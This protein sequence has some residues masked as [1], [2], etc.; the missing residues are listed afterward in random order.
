MSAFETNSVFQKGH[1]LLG[2]VRMS[3]LACSESEFAE[4]EIGSGLSF[5]G[6]L[7]VGVS[8]LEL[9]LHS[10]DHGLALGRVL[11]S[12]LSDDSLEVKL[13][14]DDEASGEEVR[15]VDVLDE[16]LDARSALNF[17]L[18]H[19]FRDGAGGSLNTGNESVTEFASLFAII[20]LLHDNSLLASSPASEEND[21]A[22][23]LHTIRKQKDGRG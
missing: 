11:K 1:L 8:L 17:L 21:N 16:G 13:V 22:S 3:L 2:V 18:G 12:L 23:F 5:A 9:S 7:R 20:D 4:E 19:L 10:L 15:V 6:T 14:F